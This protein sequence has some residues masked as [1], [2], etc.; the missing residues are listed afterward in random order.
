MVPELQDKAAIDEAL[1]TAAE[2]VHGTLDGWPRQYG[3]HYKSAGTRVRIGSGAFWL[4]VAREGDPPGNERLWHGI[5]AAEAIDGV[6]KPQLLDEYEWVDAGWR[7]RA[8]LMTLIT[9]APCSATP[10]LHSDAPVDDEW[11]T[12]LRRSLD[13]LAQV[14]TS[15]VNTRQDLVSRRIAERFGAG[16]DA[17]VN[18][19]TTAHGDLHWANV[20]N[21]GAWI[22]DWEGWGTAPLGL[23]AAFLLCFSVAV[24]AATTRVAATFSR[25]LGTPDGLRSQ[26]FA[27]AELLRMIDLHGD[28]PHLRE[29][30]EIHAGI[31]LRQLHQVTPQ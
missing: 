13:N 23:D 5:R 21:P 15:R 20:T 2:R 8:D 4:R 29:P 22:F 19:W 9:E 31:V 30:L 7:Y 28:H 10:D 17:T 12:A 25:V 11:F 26:L 14:Q 24:P 6:R 3:W 27:C 18:V 16:V 1:H